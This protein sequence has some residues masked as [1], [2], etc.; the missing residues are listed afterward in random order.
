MSDLEKKRKQVEILRVEAAK[1]EMELLIE[2]KFADIERI[3]KNIEVQSA[4]IEQ[5]KQQL[6]E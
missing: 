1:A 3:R 5:I 4:R 6:G 2:E